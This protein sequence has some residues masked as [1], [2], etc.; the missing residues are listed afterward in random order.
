VP[1]DQEAVSARVVEVYDQMMRQVIG[2][3]L[4]ELG[5]RGTTLREFRYGDRSHFGTVRWQKD[6]RRATT[7]A[8][9]CLV[10][11]GSWRT[12]LRHARTLRRTV[13]IELTRR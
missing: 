1:D 10:Q 4:R 11:L 12:T 7:K 13:T 5:F 2:P 6:G 9:G 3:A 8:V